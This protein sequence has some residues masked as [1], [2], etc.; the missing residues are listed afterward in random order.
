M[1]IVKGG[2][3]QTPLGWI[4]LGGTEAGVSR[5]TFGHT[6]RQAAEQILQTWDLPLQPWSWLPEVCLALHAYAGGDRIPLASL[7]QAPPSGT[8]FQRAVIRELLKIPYGEV[9]TYAELAKRAGRE[10]A[11]RAVGTVMSQNP[12]PLIR[13]CHRVVGSGGCLGGYSAPQG[14]QMKRLLLD[15][16]QQA[17]S[18]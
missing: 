18:Q 3:F 13:P 12:L 5:L 1:A 2:V 11:A 8:T 16:E 14:V 7:P 15:L 17:V 9:C 10:G 4:G 6:T